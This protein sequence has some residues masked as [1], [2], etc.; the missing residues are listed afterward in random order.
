MRTALLLV[1]AVVT[2]PGCRRRE[3]VSETPER[4]TT[5]SGI[6][7]V[8]I[9]EGWFEMGS[10]RGQS[11]E[12]P[13]RRVWI[14]SFWMDRHEVVQ[15]EF[16]KYELP[17]PS[18]FKGPAQPLEQVNWTDAA[19]YCND[20]SMAEGLEPCYDEQTW[21]C[22][23]DAN[24]YRLPTEAEWEY[25]CRAETVTQY[26]FGNDP[27][28]LGDHAW[29][30]ENSGS[31]TQPVGQKKP[32]RWGL[33]DMHGNV[34]EWC[35]DWYRADYYADGP[36]RNPMGPATGTERVIRGGAWNSSAESCR[37]SY[38]ASDPSLDDTCLSNDAIGFRCVRN[39]PSLALA[40]GSLKSTGL[41]DG[42]HEQ[43]VPKPRL[44]SP[45]NAASA[46][47]P[48]DIARPQSR[49]GFVYD[50]LYLEHKTGP[51]HPEAPERL[52]AIVG[53]LEATGL[54][55]ELTPLKPAPAPA[56]WIET[57]HSSK[58]IERARAACESGDRYLDS[59][60]VPISRQS[61]NAAVMAAGGVMAAV[62]AVMA[63]DVANAFCAVRPPGHH[64]LKDRATG[65]CIFNNVAIGARYVQQRHGLSRV[66]IVDW[67]VHHGNGTQDAF[68][69]DPSVLYF[70]IHQW[71]FYPGTGSAS[72]TG[73]G[74]GSD[75]TIN[76]PVPAGSGD[77][78]FIDAF[79]QQLRP[80]AM[81][82]SPD[83]VFVSAG[84]D[85]QAGDALGSMRVTREGFAHL[86]RIVKEIAQTCSQGRLISV[87]EGGY[88][89]DL[90]AASVEAHVR[91]LME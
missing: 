53:R 62:D 69:D 18:H 35:N 59:M 19:L 76:V 65:F 5:Q 61:Y 78:E 34:A 47:I 71:P 82:F 83:F 88:G 56:E 74:A 32:N 72:Q 91:A 84:F 25:A 24:G 4:Q 90:L 3:E 51:G 45:V 52:T 54:A 75:L 63:G 12:A 55:D 43:A 60:D 23:F 40:G 85:A 21:E 15:E 42:P 30:A 13:V 26:S 6:E 68:Y 50:P 58:Y 22:N 80:A 7:M 17:D 46:S 31:R 8:L 81:A 27:R 29:F 33:F 37:S 70:S 11:D 16:R 87:L 89:T 39:A 20:R 41:G 14:S 79:E 2:I 57:V 73:A 36:D 64:A 1:V 28:A 10:E 49:T 66:L 77:R 48:T 67:D 38:R 44:R 86:T 9:P